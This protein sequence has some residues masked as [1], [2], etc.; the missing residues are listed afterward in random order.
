MLD[1]VDLQ[2]I[3]AELGQAPAVAVSELTGGSSRVFK[4]DLADDTALVVKSFAADHLHPHKDAYAS[5]LLDGIDVPVTRYLLV[6]ES[7]TRLPF[8]FALTTYLDGQIATS[9]ADHPG[10]MEV[11]R[12]LGAVARKLHAIELP[13][14]GG[15]PARGGAAEHATNL[16]YM[17]G[18]VD[19]TFKHFVEFGGDP[20]MAE[21]LRE[22][23]ERDF[24]AVVPHSGP[25]V[26]AHSDLQPYN[27]LAR[28]DGGR[29]ELSGL[30]DYG[31]MRA[32]SAVMDLAKA[33]FCSEH[34]APGSTGPILDGYG[35]IN[36]PEPQKALAFYMTL[37]RLTMWYWL[38]K[39]GVM[40]SADTP[41]DIID[42]LEATAA[43]G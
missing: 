3:L 5:R 28:E 18:Y 15:I 38:R 11:F 23:V 34:D 35:P 8:R 36:H 13:A 37:H 17:R 10:Y 9:F 25:A 1:I 27:I 43:S 22:I 29:L 21:K 20:L 40:P 2:P 19:G 41:S 12:Q 14:F 32:E 24:D 4:L 7:Q 33:I 42:A 30:I 26:F 16:A 31:N 6:D 39:I